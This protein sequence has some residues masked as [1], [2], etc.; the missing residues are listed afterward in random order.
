MGQRLCCSRMWDLPR[1]GIKLASLVL[2]GRFFTTEPLGKP[3]PPLLGIALFL[4][5]PPSWSLTDRSMRSLCHILVFI[6][7]APGETFAALCVLPIAKGPSVGTG[8]Y[9]VLNG[10]S[11]TSLLGK[12]L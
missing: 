5:L 4:G 3:S 1:P 9:G 2:A 8:T 12:R 7:S 11:E 6:F 10:A